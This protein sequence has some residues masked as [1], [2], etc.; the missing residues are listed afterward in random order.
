MTIFIHLYE[1]EFKD[2]AIIRIRVLVRVSGGIR[3]P[4]LLYSDR[5]SVRASGTL[6]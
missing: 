1:F 2:K 6:S 4:C 5:N 3:I